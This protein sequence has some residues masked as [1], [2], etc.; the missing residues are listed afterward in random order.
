MTDSV[1]TQSENSEAQQEVSYGPET[2][3]ER[4]VLQE[5][6]EATEANPALD[7]FSPAKVRSAASFTTDEPRG[8]AMFWIANNG[9]HE[10]LKDNK[11]KTLSVKD[12]LVWQ[13]PVTR[14]DGSVDEKGMVTCLFLEDGRT[15]SWAS[16]ITNRQWANVIKAKGKGPFDPALRIKIVA[17]PSNDKNK[18]DWYSIMPG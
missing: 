17:N 12:W 6:I 5:A 15:V 9:K 8:A 7:E 2:E 1:Q 18:G 11:G 16:P 3:F 4:Q 14:S 10:D 13:K